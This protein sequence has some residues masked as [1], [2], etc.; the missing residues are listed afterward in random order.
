MDPRRGADAAAGL[1]QGRGSNFLY[2]R[3]GDVSGRIRGL[4]IPTTQDMMSHS[5]R[6]LEARAR[7]A[8]K[9]VGL[10]VRKS[11]WRA[12]SADNFGH[13]MLVDPDG[14]R[15]VAGSDTT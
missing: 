14:K 7:R 10:V 1:S 12:G 6:A 2:I 15:T 5:E 13:F 3:R 9:K 11:R 8:G 4:G